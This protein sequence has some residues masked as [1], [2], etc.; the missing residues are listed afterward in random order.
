MTYVSP[1]MRSGG[2]FGSGE[3]LLRIDR[4]DFDLNV[5][6]TGADFSSAQATLE[7]REAERDVAIDNYHLLNPGADVP[8]LVAKEP[9]IRQAKAQLASARARMD[10]ALLA[11]NRS[12]FTLPFDGRVTE[13]TVEVGQYLTPGQAF[14]RAFAENAVEIS[15]PVTVDEQGLLGNIK[16]RT[17]QVFAN[18]STYPVR[19]DRVAAELDQQTRFSRIYLQFVEDRIIPPGTFVEV[20]IE[21]MPLSDTYRLSESVRQ[22]NDTLWLV[23]NG[24]LALFKP[25]LLASTPDG[26]IVRAF[27]YGEGIILGTIPGARE[28]LEVQISELDL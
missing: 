5:Q 1:S 4:R 15:V 27:D 26:L 22:M 16:E 3:E 25:E 7:L 6:Q 28:G 20:E 21:G 13:S 11:L 19:I 18:G 10:S 8:T 17:G 9:Q 23:R 2:V 14:G 24:Q 12:Q